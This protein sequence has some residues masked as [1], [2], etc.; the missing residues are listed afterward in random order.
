MTARETKAQREMK[1]IRD[2]IES[3]WIA[4]VLAFVLRAFVVEAFVIP[5][6]SM[7]PTLMGRHLDLTCPACGY[8]FAFG[9][10]DG[11]DALA[12]RGNQQRY[13]TDAHCP[14]C[15]YRFSGEA[16]M[17]ASGG[18]R[19]LVLKYL[20]QF[21][22]PERWDVV[23][24]RNPQDNRENYIKR[25]I[26]LPGE[27]IEIIHGDIFA[28]RGGGPMQVQRKPAR[29][30]EAMWQVIYKNDYQPLREPNVPVKGSQTVKV[31][32]SPSAP[33][34]VAAQADHWNLSQD[35]GRV[36]K[37]NGAGD[38]SQLAF[39]APRSAFAPHYGYNSPVI[40][41]LDP[42]NDIVTDL[43]L[44]LVFIPKNGEA[45]VALST[46]SFEHQ[47]RAEVSADGS[48]QLTTISGAMTHVQQARLAEPMKIDQGY[49]VELVHVD[50]QTSIFIDGKS[51]IQTTPEQYD[52]THGQ[53]KERMSLTA[54]EQVPAPQV[55]LAAAG[56]ASEIRHVQL[57]RDVYYTSPK[58]HD[59]DRGPAGEV[60]RIMGISSRSQP[61]WGTMD[62]A[63]ALRGG[64]KES[65]LDEFYVLGDNSPQSL[66][67]RAWT[68]AAPTLK[69]W[70]D[71]SKDPAKQGPEDLLYKLGTVPRYSMIGRAMFVYWPA[72]HRLAGLPI[73]PDVGGMRLIR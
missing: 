53:L 35:Y 11:R 38:W 71:P 22:P 4:I 66:D 67:S 6:G 41:Q 14:N 9:L 29:A 20:Y 50:L 5:T 51:V 33:R 46:T 30:Q 13:S 40:E 69:L 17:L 2:T 60:A 56:G 65:D 12:S 73:I 37:F 32:A 7:A 44:S 63:I 25:L 24:F 15:D 19:V 16:G 59:V 1:V 70:K 21:R 47:F 8:D 62:N 54:R 52:V 72:G 27:T 68:A 39:M 55:R 28:S 48:V 31:A 57:M 34:W 43:K 49:S 26:G 42:A 36:F 64:E 58:I 18:D 45:K 3:I 10:H 23:V 61:G